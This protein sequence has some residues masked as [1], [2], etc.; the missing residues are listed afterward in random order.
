M[1]NLEGRTNREPAIS[2]LAA[3]LQY[4][5]RLRTLISRF[6]RTE[7][8]LPVPFGYRRPRASRM[9]NNPASV[10]RIQSLADHH[11]LLDGLLG[12]CFYIE[13]ER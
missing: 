9:I 11:A 7:R 4:S 12:F 2:R 10:R 6:K 5:L 1:G 3:L 8:F 13:G